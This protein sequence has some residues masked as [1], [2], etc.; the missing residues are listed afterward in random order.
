[1]IDASV[2]DL[3]DAA[4]K[5][6]RKGL[7][8][9]ASGNISVL[10]NDEAFL[11]SGTGA[12]L[13]S[14]RQDQVVRCSLAES[15]AIGSFQ[16]SFETPMHRAVYVERRDIRCIIHASPFYATLVASSDL[17]IDVNLT[18]D[19][20]YYLGGVGRIPYHP[21]G[22]DALAEAVA[23]AAGKHD[24]LLLENHGALVVGTGAR[25]ALTRLE[26]L[27]VLCRMVTYGA[28]GVPL[29][30]LARAQVDQFVHYMESTGAV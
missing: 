10:P 13:E 15:T 18:I 28:L 14:L 6:G 20:V 24:V 23:E 26:C 17:E 5:V 2:A 9:G 29:R 25:A 4:H 16:P 7:T 27:E 30:P 3:L 1:M 21:P 11:I 22:S 8:W 12:A 19:S